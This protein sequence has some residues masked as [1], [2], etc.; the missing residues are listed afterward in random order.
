MP[1]YTKGL[2]LYQNQLR[3]S[4]RSIDKSIISNHINS[5]TIDRLANK[6][7]DD[8]LVYSYQDPY[9]NGLGQFTRNTN[10]WIN[11]VD[12][13]SCFSPAQMSGATWYQRSGT[14]LTKKH[15]LFAKHLYPAILPGSGTPII[16]VDVNNNVIRRN[17][18]SYGFA[19]TDVAIGLLDN[20]VPDNIKIAKVL[21][22][23]YIDYF[24]TISST[25]LTGVLCVSLDQE[26]KAIL[27]ILNGLS[28]SIT[29]IDG[30]NVLL[31]T[32][33][34]NNILSDHPIYGSY[35]SFSE[36]VA[37][38]DSGNPT[39]IIMNDELVLLTAWWTT[40]GGPFVTN[41]YDK[42]NQV[43]ESLSPGQGYSLTSI[44]IELVYHKYS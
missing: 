34:V 36:S 2:K 7:P 12:N 1:L 24:D 44:N 8:R 5:N 16:F 31:Q 41:Q 15:M 18:I 26:E 35:S 9:Y 21:P 20:D 37:T 10:C 14:L 3:Y 28:S 30:Q 27:N 22:K 33:N 40:G 6:V 39:F 4:L 17:L 38:F 13:I 29:Q 25:P 23:N 43:I 11:G 32:V 42:I 19:Y